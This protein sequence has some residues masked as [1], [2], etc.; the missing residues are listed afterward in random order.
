MVLRVPLL[1]TPDGGNRFAQNVN[2]PSGEWEKAHLARYLFQEGL[3][4]F[5]NISTIVNVFAIVVICLPSRQEAPPFSSYDKF[6]IASVELRWIMFI[7][8]MLMSVLS[9]V[10][11]FRYI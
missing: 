9:V 6:R 2:N 4:P 1:A 11:E 3:V 5:R 7:K 10:T 8:Y